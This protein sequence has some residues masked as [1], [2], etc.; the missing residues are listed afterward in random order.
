M[1]R[2]CAMPEAFDTGLHG[3]DP[4]VARRRKSKELTKFAL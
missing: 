1:L 2:S 3:I 4:R